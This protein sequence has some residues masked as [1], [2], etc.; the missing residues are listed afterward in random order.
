M[1]QAHVDVVTPFLF[2][3]VA[4]LHHFY[5]LCIS[6]LALNK[7]LGQMENSPYIFWSSSRAFRKLVSMFVMPQPAPTRWERGLG[8]QPEVHN[9]GGAQ[10]P[11]W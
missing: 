4:G 5:L 3:E 10:V 2:N 9:L 8:R 7:F 6:C 1:L 11:A